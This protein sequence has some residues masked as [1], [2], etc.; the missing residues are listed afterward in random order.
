MSKYNLVKR[1]WLRLKTSRVVV[2]VD[3]ELVCYLGRQRSYWGINSVAKTKFATTP[4]LKL[5]RKTQS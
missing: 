5:P 2:V 4:G 1:R 3:V